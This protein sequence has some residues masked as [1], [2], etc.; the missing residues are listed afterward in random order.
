M[1]KGFASWRYHAIKI[2]LEL[3]LFFQ[4]QATKEASVVAVK[5]ANEENFENSSEDV[6]VA[7]EFFCICYDN[8]DK[9]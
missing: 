4:E 8:C 2:S 1:G 6:L 9:V 5:K 7:K 3:Y